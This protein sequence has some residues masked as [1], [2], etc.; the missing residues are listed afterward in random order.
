MLCQKLMDWDR[1]CRRSLIS[2]SASGLVEE[3]LEMSVSLP[4]VYT[5]CPVVRS[6]R[7]ETWTSPQGPQI[8]YSMSKAVPVLKRTSD[9]PQERK[10]S[11]QHSQF[12]CVLR[13]NYLSN[14]YRPRGSR[15]PLP[16]SAVGIYTI[17]LLFFLY[18]FEDKYS[19]L[20]SSSKAGKFSILLGLRRCRGRWE[21]AGC[22]VQPLR[23][24]HCAQS[25]ACN[26]QSRCLDLQLLHGPEIS[27]VMLGTQ[28]KTKIQSD[29]LDKES[30]VINNGQVTKVWRAYMY[31]KVAV[32]PVE[33]DLD[34]F[35]DHWA[36]STIY[37]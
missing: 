5:T 13:P 24:A 26:G 1:I 17:F 27:V 8:C 16:T 6:S 2:P 32:P 12:L 33:Q 28:N 21:A 30:K 9:G 15:R 4:G 36:I 34:T 35:G 7:L 11:C 31:G 23:A 22:R 29:N 19:E 3:V 14:L 25:S 20:N 37:T 10:I 18:A